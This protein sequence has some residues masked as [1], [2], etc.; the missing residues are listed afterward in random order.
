MLEPVLGY[1]PCYVML[2]PMLGYNPWYVTLEPM[3]GYNP[4]YVMLGLSIVKTRRMLRYVT[5]HAAPRPRHGI[6]VMLLSVLDNRTEPRA[7]NRIQGAGFGNNG[8]GHR[9]A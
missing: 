5:T 4:W 8:T 3:L 1:N 7:A 2:E 6:H 9:S